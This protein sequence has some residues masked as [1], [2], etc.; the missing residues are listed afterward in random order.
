MNKPDDSKRLCFHLSNH[1]Y[2]SFTC[3]IAYKSLVLI[4]SIICLND[5]VKRDRKEVIAKR[6]PITNYNSVTILQR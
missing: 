4:L 2:A 5:E 6:R 3:P 1:I